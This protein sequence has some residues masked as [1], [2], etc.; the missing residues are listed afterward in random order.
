M[1]VAELTVLS[2]TSS[3]IPVCFVLLAKFD[4]SCSNLAT[5]SPWPSYGAWSYKKL[6]KQT[7]DSMK[8][9]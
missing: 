1:A 8:E 3:L 2:D 7:S 9:L 4:K 6:T 5:S